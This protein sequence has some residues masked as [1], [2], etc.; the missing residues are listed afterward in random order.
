MKDVSVLILCGGRGSRMKEATASLP[1][2]LVPVHG[3]PI[4]KYILDHFTSQGFEDITLGTGYLSRKVEDF[5]ATYDPRKKIK[6]SNA[7]EEVSM[8]HR[9]DTALQDL[10]KTVVVAY[11]DTF[12]DIDYQKLVSEHQHS[13]AAMTMVTG[14]IRNPFGIIQIGD[15]GFVSNF[16]EKPVFN[17]YIGSF[18]MNASVRQMISKDMTEIPD[19][20]GV[21]ELFQ[22]LIVKQ[23]LRTFQHEGLQVT[24]NTE[25]ERNDAEKAIS[26]YYTLR[27]TTS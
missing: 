25:P 2:P 22:K 19:G 8:L 7:G 18:V 10:Q 4:L 9:I 20:Q 16:E 21:V 14:K 12:I 5:A 27:E 17:Y 23:Q 6:I 13:Q 3:H 24:F 15:R 11:G 26:Q 1:K